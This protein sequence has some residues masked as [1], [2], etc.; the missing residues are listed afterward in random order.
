MKNSISNN[1]NLG[2]I[3]SSSNT[4]IS[5]NN[6]LESP[7]K[8]PS[9]YISTATTSFGEIYHAQHQATTEESADALPAVVPYHKWRE[10]QALALAH[11]KDGIT[12]KDVQKKFAFRKKQARHLLYSYS[13][14]GKLHTAG[15]KKPQKYFLTKQDAEFAY[16]Q[17]TYNDHTGVN[18]SN[19]YH[20]YPTH[21]PASPY[22]SAASLE[23][24]LQLQE[25]ERAAYASAAD[26]LLTALAM[27]GRA[28]LG[29]HNM[30]IKVTLLH[31]PSDTAND[32]NPYNRVDNSYLEHGKEGKRNR[33]K[34]Y[35]ERVGDKEI[36]YRLYPNNT[37]MIGIACTDNPF[38]LD[39]QEHVTSLFC[40]L[41]G[42]RNV[43]R[44]W[45]SDTSDQFVPPVHDWYMTEADVNKD[46]QLTAPL[47]YHISMTKIQLRTIEGV[48]REYAKRINGHFYFRQEKMLKNPIRLTESN[49]Y[50][51]MENAHTSYRAANR[52]VGR[53]TPSIV[54]DD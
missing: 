42:M 10:V 26:T 30:H 25:Q 8:A 33:T 35:P 54:E 41:G 52:G 4:T 18:P 50:H 1:N 27:A 39:S 9:T 38:P 45:L 2:I 43:L 36:F 24:R 3:S 11:G 7:Y 28:P 13:K 15:R 53:T 21:L 47:Y 51:L 5:K 17:S 40:F 12:F 49:I 22:S 6:E 19:S 34:L 29:I 16:L 14:Q 48:F 37:V 20:D 23:H 32:D 44:L 31:D 46:A